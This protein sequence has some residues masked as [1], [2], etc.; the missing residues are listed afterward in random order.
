MK[1]IMHEEEMQMLVDKRKKWI[2]ILLHF[3]CHADDLDDIIQDMYLIVFEKLNEGTN[4]M[5]K[6]NSINYYYIFKILRS[7]FIN[8]KRKEKN[9]VIV[10]LDYLSK[11]ESDQSNTETYLKIEGELKTMY[12]YDRK[13]FEIITE[14]ENISTLSRKTGISY[15]SLYKTFKKVKNKIKKL[16]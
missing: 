8:M 6:D 5:Y 7:L 12:W 2:N 3:G 4:I 14:G 13:I 16:L 10:D 15:Y 9:T 1:I 11:I